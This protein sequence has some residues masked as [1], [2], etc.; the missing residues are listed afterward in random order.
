M[1]NEITISL[2][3]YQSI[4]ERVQELKAASGDK[5]YSLEMADHHRPYMIDQHKQTSSVKNKEPGTLA[6]Q[7]K[8]EN[9]I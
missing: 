7:E 3:V 9:E 8:K 5:Y 2:S 6:T 4:G 1:L